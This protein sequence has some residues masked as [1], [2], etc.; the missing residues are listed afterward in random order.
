MSEVFYGSTQRNVFI[1]LLDLIKELNKSEPTINVDF[2]KLLAFHKS[3]LFEVEKEVRLIYDRR[4]K[5]DGLH[6]RTLYDQNQLIF[7][8]I[9][10][11]LLKLVDNKDKIQYL[12]LPLYNVL[13]KYYE[14]EIPVLK[15]ERILVGYNFIA[16]VPSLIK[17]ITGLCNEQ[18]GYIPII[19]QTR[20]KN[21]YWD[22][23][24]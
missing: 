17:S 4:T 11:D 8:I 6:H 21:F 13:S 23:K 7:P 15:I 18:L 1:K 16:E 14:P 19:K 10:S 9:K 2:G 5:R 22:I 24:K 3:R 20:L 12:K